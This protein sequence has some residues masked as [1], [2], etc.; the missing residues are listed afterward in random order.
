MKIFDNSE[1]IKKSENIPQKKYTKWFDYDKIKGSIAIRTRKIGDYLTVN[2]MNQRKT[3]KSYFI[4][5]KISKD[6]R[7]NMLLLADESHIMWVIGA[8]ISNY[9]K[10]SGDTAKILCVTYIHN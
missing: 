5:E 9:Y 6:E 10:V 2:S 1:K 8:R 7:D 3:I 4:D